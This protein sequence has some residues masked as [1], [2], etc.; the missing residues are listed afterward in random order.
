MVLNY[1]LLAVHMDGRQAFLFTKYF[2]KLDLKSLTLGRLS[3]ILDADDIGGGVIL[4][5]RQARAQET[6]AKIIAAAEKLISEKGF[7]A[8]QIIDITNEAGVG[9]G[10]FYTYFKRKEDV[11]AEIAHNKFESIHENSA[12][13]EGDIC[14]R[15]AA[16]L[17][18]SMDYIK[19]TGIRIAQQWV[20]GVV[21]PD[22]QDGVQKLIYD[23][24]V[25]WSIL[26]KA[27]KNSELKKQTPLE[28]LTY[29]IA[30]QYYGVVFCWSLT[31]GEND[32]SSAINDFC[33]GMLREYLTQYRS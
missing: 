8:V 5:V 17:T 14:D 18:G 25:I 13:Q 6:R 23:R 7:D 32:P 20:K 10:S 26:D 15:I 11:V 2:Q 30:S 16:Y 24:Q 33:Q 3:A 28:S 21:D 31:D 12:R 19:E 9:K 27:V 29:W 4:K 22:N 1:C